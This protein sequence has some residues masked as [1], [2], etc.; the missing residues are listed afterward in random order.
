MSERQLQLTG[1]KGYLADS[2]VAPVAAGLILAR[3]L[4][5]LLPV[6]KDRSLSDSTTLSFPFDSDYCLLSGNFM[7]DLGSIYL[8]HRD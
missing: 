5:D 6:D 1:L 8:E 7:E 3:L 2:G 4:I